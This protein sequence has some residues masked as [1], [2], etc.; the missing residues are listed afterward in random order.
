MF[1][2]RWFTWLLPVRVCLL[3]SFSRVIGSGFLINRCSL[4][5]ERFQGRE[6]K[7]ERRERRREEK[8]NG[9]GGFVGGGH[10]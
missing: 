2:V 8:R 10:A 5:R 7:E 3:V 6:K 4:L 9:L 1:V